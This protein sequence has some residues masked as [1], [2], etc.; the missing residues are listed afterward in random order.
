MNWNEI[1]F[2]SAFIAFI[3]FMLFVDLI[4]VGKKSHIVSFKESISWTIVWVSISMLF[5]III[6]FHGD[7]IHGID[8]MEKLK[9]LIK[10]HD[11]SIQ[12]DGLD[13][14]SAIK[15]YNHNLSLEYLTGYLIEYALSIDNVFVMILIFISFNVQQKFYKRVLF[16]GIIGAIVMRFIFIFLSATLIQ[17][18]EWILYLF[19]LLL[20][21]TGIK[22]FLTRNKEEKMD[23]EK[24]PVVKF[25][26]KYF[27]VYPR[28]VQQHFVIRKNRKTYIT[29]LLIV[30]LV[31][32]FTDV[33]FAVDSVPAIFSVTKDPYI[34]FFS[35]IFA[36]IGLRSLF[37]LLSN[38]MNKFRFLKVGLAAL[39]TFIGL[40]MIFNHWLKENGFTTAHSLYVVLAILSISV[41]ASLLIPER[42]QL[43]D[44]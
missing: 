16:W 18:F 40:K 27:A 11:H 29:P 9:Y 20:I 17:E 42:K 12:I 26:S 14:D 24:H 8:S 22:M 7:W 33:I 19:G 44:L 43:I 3:V 5:Y 21:F 6:R 41:I 37:F 2:F 13:F 30:L 1:I 23:A 10:I 28:F 36:I 31:I 38:I 39:L 32:E 34:V 15:V 35:N 4:L 25:A